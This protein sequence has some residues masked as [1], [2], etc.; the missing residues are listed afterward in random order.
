MSIIEDLIREAIKGIS[1][2]GKDQ[3]VPTPNGGGPGQGFGGAR[4]RGVPGYPV[5][6]AMKSKTHSEP[7]EE[8]STP[9]Q[10][11]PIYVS[12]V[13]LDWYASVND[14]EKKTTRNMA[15]KL[16]VMGN[17]LGPQHMNVPT[18]IGRHR[19]PYLRHETGQNVIRIPYGFTRARE[20]V[21]LFGVNKKGKDSKAFQVWL[22]DQSDKLWDQYIALKLP[23][24]RWDP[25]TGNRMGESVNL[26]LRDVI[27]E[28]VMSE[29]GMGA[30]ETGVGGT[31]TGSYGSSA[32][33]RGEKYGD[34]TGDEMFQ[35]LQRSRDSLKMANH[36]S[37]NT[38]LP[39]FNPFGEKDGGNEPTDLGA[40]QE[41]TD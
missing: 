5:P 21:L 39:G 8:V 30:L 24:F 14:S 25:R 28:A 33:S 26:A 15:M 35:H 22:V 17:R 29:M 31:R 36:G 2:Y 23:V 40:D 18:G 9:E 20:A 6:P 3:V 27:V 32:W 12:Q 19:L 34:M 13:F 37:P 11:T 7:L 10:E 38:S 16:Q 1:T 41:R 4:N